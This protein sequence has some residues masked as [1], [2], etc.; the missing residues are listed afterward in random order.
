MK[1][2]T[3]YHG[4]A[5]HKTKRIKEKTRNTLWV[6]ETVPLTL[7]RFVFYHIKGKGLLPDLKRI[8]LLANGV[9][10]SGLEGG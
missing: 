2:Q 8:F 9:F 6:L 1:I 7:M 5:H 10:K 3:G 4:K